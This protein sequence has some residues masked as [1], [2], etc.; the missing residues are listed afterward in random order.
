MP[1]FGKII[2]IKRNG[3]DG[4]H[5]P[6]TASSCLFGRKTECDIRIQLPQVSKEH[7]KIEVNENKEA[8]LTNLS[9][10]NP[11]QLNGGCFQQPVPLKHGDVLTII[12]RSFRFEYPPQSTPRKRR[13]RSPKNETLQVLH[14]QQVAEV[15]LLHKQASGSKSL[16][17]SDNTK[18]EK[19]NADE[20]KQ[21]TEENKVSSVKLTTK[22]LY[23]INRSNKRENEMS[24]FSKLY[25]TLKH[26]IKVKKTLQEGNASQQARKDGKSVL[27][28]SSTQMSSDYARSLGSLT[29]ET[30]KE[31]TEEYK[32]KQEVVCSE[33]NLIA[34]T[35]SAAKRSFTRSPRKSASNEM[36]RNICRK[37]L[38]QDYK[39]QN[40][41]GKPEDTE[42]ATKANEDNNGNA[43][44]SPKP[45]SIECLGYA[46]RISSSARKTEQLAQTSA[47]TKA[48][49]KNS[50]SEVDTC[51]LST[52]RSK[53]RSSRSRPMSSTKEIS[54]MGSV[55]VGA[56]TNQHDVLLEPKVFSEISA[57]PQEEDV[58]CRSESLEELPLAENACLKQRRGSK[59]HTPG[60]CI[61][62]EAL[63]ENCDQADV[64]NSEERDSETPA[65]LPN[66]KSPRRNI[67]RSKAL[68]N[69]G[70]C[71]EMQRSEELTPEV[72]SPASQKNSPGRKRGR[73]RTSALLSQK[74]VETE[75]VQDHQD[76]TTDGKDAGTEEEL[77]TKADQQ[78]LDLE[79]AG[80]TRPRSL[81]AKRR[82]G[83]STVL[84][85]DEVVAETSISSLLANEE[86]SG[87]TRGISQKRKSGDLL[88]Q[89]L[90]K[91][92]RV[93]FGGHLSPE[94]FDKSLP[95]NSPLKR[96][97]IP[98][99]LSVP[100]GGSPRAVLKKAQGSKPLAVQEL[101]EHLSKEKTSPNQRSPAASCPVSGKSTP[102]KST[103]KLNLSSPEPYT[104]GRFSVS[105]IPTPSPV[106]EEQD[107]GAK[108]VN[109]QERNNAR[110]KTP[111]S[112]RINQDDETLIAA[113]NKLTRSAQ[114]ALKNTPMKRRS[115][116][117][118][119]INAKRRS[120]ASSANLLVA[121]SWAEV[122]KLG[123]A[124]PQAKAIK[125]SVL[126]G[127]STKKIT[128]L[129]KTPE[130]KVKGHFS[131]GHAES[132]ATIVVGRAYT[133]TVR[134]AGQVPK[135]VKNPIVKQSMDMNESFTGMAEMFQTPENKSR[136]GRSL[137]PVQK[138]DFTP[139]CS[140]VDVSE[141]H[142]PEESGEMIVSPLNSSDASE[143]KPD[144]CH[145]LRDE[146]SLKSMVDAVSTNTPEKQEA[147]Q[148]ENA[149]MDSLLTN[150]KKCTSQVKLGLKGRTPKQKLEPVEV[151]SG[152]KQLMRTPKQKPE[153]VDV[154]SGVK[155]I[156]KTPKQKPEP[157]E[158]LSG[159][160]QL[161]RTPKQKPEPVEVLSGVKQLMRT[162]KQ[163]PEPAEVLSGV[164]QLMRT[165]K[166]KPEPAEVL[167]GVKQLMRTPKQ[168]PE[169]AE[170]LSGVKQ[171]MRTPKQKPEP[172]EV[173]SGVKQLMR[174]PKQ[175]PE[176]A[177]VLSGVKQL[178]RTPKQKSE[179]TTDEIGFKRLLKTPV[180]TET[181]MSSTTINKKTPKTKY[182]PVEDMIG[183][184]RIFKTP[185]EK[186]EPVEDVFGISRLVRTPKEK[187]EPVED[188]VGLK[189]LMA[190]PR[191]KCSDIEVEFTGVKEM[192]DIPEEI[193]TC[194]VKMDLEQ[195]D[196]IPPCANS[197]QECADKGKIS[198]GE[199]SQQTVSAS[200]EQCT[201]RQ[202]RG[203]PRKT[204]CPVSVNQHEKNLEEDANVKEMKALEKKSIQEEMEV[205]NASVAKSLG[206]G[207]RTNRCVR[208][209]TVSEHMNHKNAEAGEL[210]GAAQRPRRGKRNEPKQLKHQSESVE[211]RDKDSSLLQEESANV[212]QTLQKYGVTDIL[213]T[214][215]GQG[216][217]TESM[218]SHVQNANCQ[219]LQ[220]EFEIT[221]HKS[222]EGSIE[223]SE[224]LLLPPRNASKGEKELETTEPVISPRR[225]RR[226]KNDQGNRSP[227]EEPRGT[228]RKLRK[229]PSAKIAPGDEQ[230]LDKNIS[231]TALE[232]PEV[233]SKQEIKVVGRRGKSIRTTRKQ[234]EI[235]TENCRMAPEDIRNIQEAKEA[236]VETVFETQ[237][238]MKNERKVSRGKAAENVQENATEVS[239]RLKSESPSGETN[240]APAADLRLET[241][242]TRNRR[243][244]KDSLEI[245]ADEPVKDASSRKAA[246][247]KLKSE[248]ELEETSVQ[249]G[250]SSPRDKDVN[251]AAAA[252]QVPVT[253]SDSMDHNCQKQ[254]EDEQEGLEAQPVE[255]VQEGQTQINRTALRRGR[256]RRVN[257]ELEEANSKALG[258]SLPGDGKGIADKGG[259]PST[260]ENASSQV[261]R[262][263]RRQVA[264]IPPTACSTSAEKLT[265]IEDHSK[266]ETLVK[267][268]DPALEATL[269]SAEENPLR[270]G[271]RGEVAV[272]SQTTGSLSVSKRRGLPEGDDKKMPVK[273]D[274]NTALGNKTSQAKSNASAR[275]KRK[276]IDPAAEAKSS[277]SLQRKHGLSETDDKEKSSNEEQN[278]P[279]ETV[280]PAREKPLGR[281]RRKETALMS[282][283]TNCIS[284]RG[285]RGVPADNGGEKA[286]KENQEVPLEAVVASSVKETQL[287]RGRRKEVALLSEATS[288]TSIQR[289]RGVSEENKAEKVILENTASQE[290]MNLVKAN[291][292]QKAK[293]ASLEVQF[294]SPQGKVGLQDSGKNETRE[295]QQSCSVE[296]VPPAHLSRASR[297]R[298][299]SF[300][301]EEAASTF[302]RE[303]RL[304][305]DVDQKDTFKE[306]KNS[307]LDNNSSQEKARPLRNKSK[308]TEFE[309]EEPASAPLHDNG[310]L[311]ENGST[312]K[313][314]NKCLK[315]TD[316]PKSNPPR[317]GREVNL[318]PQ[319]TTRRRK[320]QLP[321]DDSASKKLKSENDENGS[322]QKGRRNKTK[323][324]LDKWDGTTQQTAGG[325]DRKTRS[326]TSTRTRH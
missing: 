263:R 56:P 122:V 11:T 51:V 23:R 72:V 77:V 172:V 273:E 325:T 275:D 78:K 136:K 153:P 248:A 45:C 2:V 214:E 198:E 315:S 107:A 186:A 127:R 46:D 310:N 252:A 140:A 166:Q 189:K 86:E 212:K 192:F 10:V 282:H 208:E 110:V 108:D 298:T 126:K 243:G 115:G 12:D 284:L 272:A 247:P 285:R 73:P 255:I 175:K 137:S 163:K 30:E 235:K 318:V 141:L 160:K 197:T 62:E 43:A 260:S 103:P 270:W 196:A 151:L 87:N 152:V 28:E 191:Q 63:K 183:I 148:E 61:K 76:K 220:T 246:V 52:P 291:S 89:P 180:E 155:R 37:I 49:S 269:S 64:V 100:F 232:K 101:P 224:T 145:F 278:L 313:M 36:S 264:S 4:I 277:S 20:N 317:R 123:V 257:F 167:S 178:M 242:R 207:R 57:E 276:K 188:F 287:R 31:T 83:C 286:L 130:R 113:T 116:A 7:C 210:C 138:I 290:K 295:E 309:S 289:K 177:E 239:Q 227:S 245:K 88:H 74:A 307:S 96:G 21:S 312:S 82:S 95:P 256:G 41:L 33:F 204:V 279:L 237:S 16:P 42:V 170:V 323:E 228:A 104:T 281:G 144:I 80:D 17:D 156:M 303:K 300:K 221:E 102:K 320:C 226:R 292:R 306:D 39:E 322:L 114:L 29:K 213:I 32:V 146:S 267:D 283:P 69:D 142:T 135:V 22:S 55:N 168:K 157:V 301:P 81:S 15:E 13:S 190:E 91:R 321:E 53:R 109:P 26:E 173:L 219:P 251:E 47:L 205:A 194:S 225:G 201:K 202:T 206:R 217:K 241:S 244:K 40:T 14:V 311:P 129:P 314:P 268:Q 67:R 161:M 60:K 288:S 9:A 222:K 304:P 158:V 199:K 124:R 253:D 97:A 99:R 106:A 249:G 105:H 54:G 176:P 184:S 193:K 265:V 234:T 154:L 8:V 50:A 174:T 119:V 112:S 182:Q 118:A 162:P 308:K 79:G 324:E 44:C 302:L 305:K 297:K 240:K 258:K 274:Q 238:D 24:P 68:S 149:G 231:E 85:E 254:A 66:S 18:S 250:L 128:Q 187:C 211:C 150:P 25:E 215:A 195:E 294:T 1:L 280:S 38:L 203:R 259:Q 209:E 98:A 216:I 34:A 296:I 233:R 132:P 93:S 218:S 143:Q 299:V 70:V 261:R 6:L 94:L 229:E 65:S 125:K 293:I 48:A 111:N 147:M 120:G 266:D 71:S 133:T 84:K 92:K 27:L 165:P 90:G 223:N 169:P 131:T 35:G 59:Q 271:R 230:A 134:M 139:T 117:V 164:K 236:F 179:A 185:K 159:V 171:L 19:Q 75:A 316:P 262:S 3:T 319:V 200:K 121:K 58:L 181:D 326:R 5:F